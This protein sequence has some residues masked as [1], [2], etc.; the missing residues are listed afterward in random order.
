MD[1]LGVAPDRPH[2]HQLGGQLAVYTK[3]FLTNS[4]TFAFG[5]AAAVLVAAMEHNM[6]AEK[7]SRRVRLTS[8]LAMFP[9]GVA[10]LALIAL[11]N[12]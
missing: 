5:M 7:L 1:D 10:M 11:A 12:P 2:C 4:D 8:F 9:V 3:T 6:I